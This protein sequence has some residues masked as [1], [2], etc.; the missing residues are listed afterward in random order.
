MMQ[1]TASTSHKKSVLFRKLLMAAILESSVHPHFAD[2]FDDNL[3]SLITVVV[4]EAYLNSKVACGGVVA[5]FR[6]QACWEINRSLHE[7]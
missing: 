1:L 7:H 3:R 2:F 6:F 5:R 4:D